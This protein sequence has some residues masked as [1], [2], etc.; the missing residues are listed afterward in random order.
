MYTNRLRFHLVIATLFIFALAVQAQTPNTKLKTDDVIM[1]NV[2]E[3]ANLSRETAV[4]M[5]GTIN[6]PVVGSIKVVGMSLAE[7]AEEVRKALV[8]AKYLKNPHVGITLRQI[9]KPRVSVLGMVMRP[10]S[11]EFKPG[12][13]IMHAVSMAGS[14][15]IER[16]KLRE[17]VL[18]RKDKNGNIEI[19]KIDLD[20][21]FSNGDMTQNLEL[22]PEDVI[23]VPE[24]TQNKIYVLGKVMRPGVFIWKSNMT[25]LNA[26]NQAGGQREEGTL[27]KVYVIRPNKATP[28]KPNRIEINLLKL[29]DKGD[30]TQDIALAPGDTLY[31]PKVNK[32]NWNEL[33]QTL[34]TIAI[35]RNT[36][37][38]KDFYKY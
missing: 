11:F 34:A 21:I 5:D 36:F 19:I 12:E 4:S 33:Y 28:D 38:N 24:D 25:V 6:M 17:A 13:T 14:Y 1:I 32:P 30:T 37:L 26:L 16:A 9:N 18:R 23:F 27:S 31:I 35:A 29:I 22:M 15:D 3:D 20:N 8:D 7:V 10:G 2:I